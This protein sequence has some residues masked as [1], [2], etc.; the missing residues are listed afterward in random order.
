MTKEY[1]QLKNR[2]QELRQ[3]NKLPGALTREEK[4]SW[5]YGN[6]VIENEDVTRSMAE[7]AVEKLGS[8]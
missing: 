4:I 6:A 3:A 5:V 1:D 8:K 7:E 2:L